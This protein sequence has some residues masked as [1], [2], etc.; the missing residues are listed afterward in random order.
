[1]SR[2]GNTLK[3]PSKT[4][5]RAPGTDSRLSERLWEA[6]PRR[7]RRS[8]SGKPFSDLCP[9]NCWR[10]QNANKCSGRS[11]SGHGLRSHIHGMPGIYGGAENTRT[12]IMQAH[13][14]RSFLPGCQARRGQRMRGPEFSVLETPAHLS[15]CQMTVKYKTDQS[16]I[17]N[18]G[19]SMA[20]P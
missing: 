16:N 5:G 10:S 17:R 4:M 15:I 3:L 19:F 2:F 12:K 13:T 11:P 8:I 7:S 9:A 1:M 18:D 14:Q 6:Q 20:A